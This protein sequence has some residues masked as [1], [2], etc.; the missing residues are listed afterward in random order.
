LPL[1][2]AQLPVVIQALALGFVEQ[3]FLAP[4]TV[5]DDLILAAFA[6]LAD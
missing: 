5:T 6:A 4:D 2:A 1:P 3:S